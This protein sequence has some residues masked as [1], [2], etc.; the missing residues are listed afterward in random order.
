MEITKELQFNSVMG[1]TL[2]FRNA[3]KCVS[4]AHG[5]Y[6][7]SFVDV[8][9]LSFDFRTHLRL[10]LKSHQPDNCYRVRKASV[11]DNRPNTLSLYCN[12]T[13]PEGD[14]DLKACP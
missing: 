4:T 13:K 3:V 12:E 2:V 1:F 7:W 14:P 6:S 5:L 10:V 9:P 8:R 11:N